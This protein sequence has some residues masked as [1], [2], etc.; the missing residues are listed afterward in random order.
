MRRKKSSSCEVGYGRPPVGSRF[1][2]TNQPQRPPKYPEP[3]GKQ[4]RDLN[5][6]RLPIMRRDGT[7]KLEAI[8]I[9]IAERM[10]MKAING[11]LTAAREVYKLLD[12]EEELAATR[13]PT[14]SPATVKKLGRMTREFVGRYLRIASELGQLGLVSD[15]A[16]ECRI[17]IKAKAVAGRIQ[18]ADHSSSD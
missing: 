7:Q 11:N 9:L 6:E 16:G 4:M 3:K 14:P 2:A 5:N 13:G 18:I 17:S 12:A 15:M 10:I 1:S 8:D